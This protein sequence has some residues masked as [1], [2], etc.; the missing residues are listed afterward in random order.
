MLSFKKPD[1]LTPDPTLTYAEKPAKVVETLRVYTL[2]SDEKF[3]GINLSNWMDDVPEEKIEAVLEK[4]K[5]DKEFD[6]LLIKFFPDQIL[7][8]EI[9]HIS[10]EKSTINEFEE[11]LNAS[12]KY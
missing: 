2:L 8:Q 10:T 6:N 3:K 11:A 7:D 1:S 5:D 9:D 4:N 12:H